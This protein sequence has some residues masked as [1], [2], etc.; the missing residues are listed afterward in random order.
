MQRRESPRAP[1]AVR[2]RTERM[3]RVLV[4]G[5]IA[6]DYCAAYAGRFNALPR[7]AGINLSIALERMERR[8]GGCAANIAYSLALLGCRPAPFAFVGADFDAGYARHLTAAGVDLSGVARVPGAAFS[9]HGFVFTDSDGNQFTGFYSGPARVPD[10]A[11]RLAALLRANAFD[12]AV[13]APDVATNMIAAARLVKAA[14][15]P[16]LG[17]PGQC[18]TDFSVAETAELAGL[19]PEMAVNR[20][21]RETLRERCGDGER[22]PPRLLVTAGAAGA[23]C[24]DVAVPAAPARRIE[25]PTGCGDA[26]RA[27]YV[28]ARLR[29]AELSDAMRAGSVAAAACIEA[30]GAQAHRLDG[31]AAR[32]VDAWGERPDWLAAAPEAP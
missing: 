27:G 29:G 6:I 10:Y 25:D 13:L 9:S 20:Y 26:W 2:A 24:G 21:E 28:H 32:Y 5:A 3:P 8:F 14:G 16:F 23:S 22:L 18:L 11:P 12:Y 17:D 1:G 31:F 30:R 4:T 7:H 15:V 19:C